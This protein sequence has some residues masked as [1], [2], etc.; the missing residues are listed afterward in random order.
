MSR[1]TKSSGQRSPLR[2]MERWCGY[3]RTPSCIS[4]SA[5]ASFTVPISLLFFFFSLG[6]TPSS[7]KPKKIQKVLRDC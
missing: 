1:E 2:F 6:T 4:T 3:E 5:V 7:A